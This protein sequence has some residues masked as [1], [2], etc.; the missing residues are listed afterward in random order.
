MKRLNLFQKHFV[1]TISVMLLIVILIHGLIYSLIPKVYLSQKRTQLETITTDLVDHLEGKSIQYAFD[2]TENFALMSG[3]NVNLATAQY[4]QTFLGLMQF[5]IHIRE[6]L[7]LQELQELQE[8]LFVATPGAIDQAGLILNKQSFMLNENTQANIQVMMSVQPVYEIK[9]ATLRL[10]PY[11]FLISIFISFAAAFYFSKKMSQPIRDLLEITEKMAAFEKDV[12][13]ESEGQDEVV[14]LGYNINN[15]YLKLQTAIYELED[16]IKEMYKIERE[17]EHF[18]KSASHE[19]KTPLTSLSVLLENMQLN[20]GVYQDRDYYLKEALQLV[21]NAN[22]KISQILAASDFQSISVQKREFDLKQYIS[23]SLKGYQHIIMKKKLLLKTDLLAASLYTDE[24]YFK[25]VID[26]LLSNAFFY[27]PSYGEVSVD[28][29]SQNLIIK[30]ELAEGVHIDESLLFEPFYRE[31]T[32]SSSISRGT[33]LGLY[34]VKKNLELLK[35]DF[36]VEITEKSF[37]FKI[38]F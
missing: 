9:E 4:R 21:T 18:F 28:L 1:Y 5:D 10:I 14:A 12:F 30:N 35:L 16:N 36:E 34:L 32:S 24:L 7:S 20:I 8:N 6:D 25:V 29:S 26:N 38:Y 31:D 2:F 22:D 3:T 15:M 11:S 37:I 17:K 27:T 13:F 23:L 33:G 19:L